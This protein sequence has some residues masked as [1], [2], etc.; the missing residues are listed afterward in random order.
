MFV[1]QSLE[2]SWALIGQ[3]KSESVQVFR[4]IFA[5]KDA[6]SPTVKSESEIV[7]YSSVLLSL[8]RTKEVRY[9]AIRNMHSRE[10]S[11]FACGLGDVRSDSLP[12]KN[13]PKKN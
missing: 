11:K 10:S 7:F 2:F 13:L 8:F 12:W 4:R 3:C 1:P 5:K 9:I 6:G